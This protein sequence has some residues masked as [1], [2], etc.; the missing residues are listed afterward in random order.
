MGRATVAG[1]TSADLNLLHGHHALGWNAN[2]VTYSSLEISS[3]EIILREEMPAAYVE[4][5]MKSVEA[6]RDANRR[7]RPGGMLKAQVPITLHAAWRKEWERGPKQWGVL[8]RA[9]LNG[10]LH[11]RDYSR[12]L[13]AK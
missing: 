12:F 2:G 5:I 8:W 11:H 3:E 7:R 10:K 9:F 13:A 6:M 1:L 4:D